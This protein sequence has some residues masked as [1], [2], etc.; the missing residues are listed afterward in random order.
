MNT[1]PFSILLKPV[2]PLTALTVVTLYSALFLIIAVKVSPFHWVKDQLMQVGEGWAHSCGALAIPTLL[3]GGVTFVAAIACSYLGYLEIT[4]AMLTTSL[5]C[6][7]VAGWAMAIGISLS[8]KFTGVQ[9]FVIVIT[10][11]L[12]AVMCL[13]GMVC[14]EQNLTLSQLVVE[15]Q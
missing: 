5:Y 4:N 2:D 8:P 1:S 10:C 11:V 3:I 15:L 14:L 6:M 12:I 13:A 9:E 7:M